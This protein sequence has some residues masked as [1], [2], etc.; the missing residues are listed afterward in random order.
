MVDK[1]AM[2]AGGYMVGRGWIISGTILGITGLFYEDI[3]RF[4][5]LKCWP[6]K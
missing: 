3:L 2:V 1:I 5:W 4:L 6:K